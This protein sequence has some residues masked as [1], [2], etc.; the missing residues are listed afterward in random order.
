MRQS[1]NLTAPIGWLSNSQK[2]IAMTLIRQALLDHAYAVR[3]TNQVIAAS[4]VD[5][6][7][8]SVTQQN[9]PF[10]GSSLFTLQANGL[11]LLEASSRL[12]VANATTVIAFEWVDSANVA[13]PDKAIATI[14]AV[15]NVTSDNQRVM[16]RIVFRPAVLTQMKL[17]VVSGVGLP[18]SLNGGNTDAK[19]LRIG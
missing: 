6:I 8:E 15:T 18:G 4:P 14:F 1:G 10:D 16:A 13:P 11:Y 12:V 19:I 17:R 7:W 3:S 2:G 5:V 9:I